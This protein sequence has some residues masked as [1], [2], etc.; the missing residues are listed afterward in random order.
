M[1]LVTRLMTVLPNIELAN[2]YESI[3]TPN[4]QPPPPP[5]PTAIPCP[6]PWSKQY[7]SLPDGSDH[8]CRDNL[9]KEVNPYQH[10]HLRSNLILPVLKQAI[11]KLNDNIDQY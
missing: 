7:Y 9:Q 1:L 6:T 4:P 11:K 10:V 5:P 8:K 3:L 2:E